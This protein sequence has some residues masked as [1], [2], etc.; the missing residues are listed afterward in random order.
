MPTRM[1]PKMIQITFGEMAII[2]HPRTP[3]I[4]AILIVFS[5]PMPSIISPLNI[6]ANGITIIKTLAEI[7][8]FI[9]NVVII[10]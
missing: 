9:C 2:H 10:S 3:G 6:E 4:L 5:L 7:C 8:M 1:R